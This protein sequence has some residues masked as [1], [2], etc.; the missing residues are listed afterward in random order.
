MFDKGR[1]GKNIVFLF[2]RKVISFF[3]VFLKIIEQNIYCLL[4]DTCHIVI[5][6]MNLIITYVAM[7][8]YLYFF[9]ANWR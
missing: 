6:Q 1:W 2:Q 8:Q 7:V 3:F 5:N 4:L 9:Y